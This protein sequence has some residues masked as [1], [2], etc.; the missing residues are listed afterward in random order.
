MKQMPGHLKGDQLQF[1]DAKIL[2]VMESLIRDAGFDP[3]GDEWSF[4]VFGVHAYGSAPRPNKNMV[5][6]GAVRDSSRHI[7]FAIRP[8][9]GR[10]HF[11]VRICVPRSADFIKAQN[12][13]A[14]AI[15]RHGKPVTPVMS[16]PSKNGSHKPDPIKK[17]SDLLMDGVTKLEGLRIGL[18]AVLSMARDAKAS[19]EMREEIQARYDAA[20]EAATP[21]LRAMGEAEDLLKKHESHVNALADDIET[22]QAKLA[23]LTERITAAKN[24]R[25]EAKVIFDRV[26]IAAEEPSRVWDEVSKELAEADRLEAERLKTINETP[27]ITAMLSALE[28]MNAK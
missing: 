12:G 10:F 25:D 1:F 6:L 27:G 22:T 4:I 14:A 20:K 26:A 7:E 18:D 9:E 2:P 3:R 13:I 17:P 8:T 16:E 15:A 21:L 5:R 28:A 24:E 23:A 11:E 19:A